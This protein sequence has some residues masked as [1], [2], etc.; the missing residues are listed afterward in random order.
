MGTNAVLPDDVR[1]LW[2]REVCGSFNARYSA[3]ARH[4]RYVIL[5]RPTRPALM[6]RKVTWCFYPLDEAEM[7]KA[8][9][10]LLGEHDFSSFRAQGCQSVSPFRRMH[11]IRVERDDDQ[12]VIDLVA[13]AFLH[14]M[15]RNIVGVLMAVGAGRE[16]SGWSKVVLEARSRCRAGVTAPADGLYFAGVMYPMPLELPR[17]PI[18]SALSADVTRFDDRHS[19][20][21]LSLGPNSS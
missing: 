15:V 6:R 19:H 9:D 20:H 16:Q 4:Y 21:E 14:H 2:A 13:N 1:V 7:Q 3:I 12:V 8:A 5:N 18:F 10:H 17:S 11:L